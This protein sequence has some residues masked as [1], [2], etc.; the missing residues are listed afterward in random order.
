MLVYTISLDNSVI[1]LVTNPATYLYHCRLNLLIGSVSTTH[2]IAYL[3]LL[4]SICSSHHHGLIA[5]SLANKHVSTSA[6]LLILAPRFVFP[7]ILHRFSPLLCAGLSL[8]VTLEMHC[9]TF[10]S[11][12]IPIILYS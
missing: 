4:Q 5:V 12:I 9:L 7:H 6:L 10:P 1:Y 3:S 11:M 8:N 2:L